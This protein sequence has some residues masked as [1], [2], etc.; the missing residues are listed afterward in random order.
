MAVLLELFDDARFIFNYRRQKM[1]VQ[2]SLDRSAPKVG[3]TAPDFT[4]MDVDGQNTV[5]LSDYRGHKPVALIFG[6]YT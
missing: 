4:L 2:K 6:S 1:G 5:T 3:D